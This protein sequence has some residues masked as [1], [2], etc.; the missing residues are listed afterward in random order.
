[1]FFRTFSFP[2]ILYKT[3]DLANFVGL[4]EW[5]LLFPV[6]IY[7]LCCFTT[8]AVSTLYRVL[9]RDT[10]FSIYLNEHKSPIQHTSRNQCVL[11]HGRWSCDALCG[12]HAFQHN[13]HPFVAQRC[14]LC[15]KFLV[16]LES[17][18][19]LSP[20]VAVIHLSHWSV[21]NTPKSLG[22][23]R[24][25]KSRGLRSGDHAGQLTGPPRPIH[26]SSKA[27]F[28]CCL[29][30][31]RKWDG[32]PSCKNRMCCRWWRGTCYKITI[33]SFSKKR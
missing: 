9:K 18:D 11:R 5:K 16:S 26:C 12:S 21:L 1:M 32:A 30:I 23:P 8:L 17:P 27:W 10:G 22:V 24:A 29:A 6:C 33:R 25:K 7:F 19:R 31:R 4:H 3:L 14:V 15:R 2:R 13:F 20:L 28:G